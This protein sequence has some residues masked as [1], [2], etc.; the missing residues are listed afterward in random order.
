MARTLLDSKWSISLDEKFFGEKDADVVA[1]RNGNENFI[2]V[3]NLASMS[4]RED[5]S[6]TAYNVMG[7]MSYR[8]R[9]VQK[10]IDKFRQRFEVPMARG[11]QGRAWVALHFA[12]HDEENVKAF[13]QDLFDLTGNQMSAQNAQ[14]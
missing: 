11:W 10:V 6:V 7:E 1:R 8:N 9:I 5:G 4:L 3:I 2:D 12:K 13:V 14:N